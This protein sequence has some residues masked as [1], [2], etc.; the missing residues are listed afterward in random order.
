[1]QLRGTIQAVDCD[2]QQ[3]VL[4]GPS[5]A[6]VLRS[7]LA[8]VVRVN[9]AIASL[10]ALTPFVGSPATVSVLAVGGQFVI[11]QLDV[12]APVGASAPPQAAAYA[13]SSV[14]VPTASQP[15]GPAPALAGAVL[16]TVQLGGRVFLLV[17]AASGVLYRYPYY[18]PYYRAY[19]APT[20]RP[21]A[22]PYQYAPAF[23]Y[24][25][26]RRCP[27]RTWSQWCR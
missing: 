23:T 16:G 4:A 15:P 1:V 9:G 6:T 2:A 25:P 11:A 26:Y 13:P 8:T 5:G 7:V 14:P 18:G 19:Y 3:L 21:Y 20:Y 27:D 17:Q 10:C 22:G 24:G 12:S